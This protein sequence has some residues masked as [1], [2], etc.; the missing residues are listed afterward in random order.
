VS[1]VVSA[2]LRPTYSFVSC[3]QGGAVLRR[4]SD[5]KSCEFTLSL[6]VERTGAMPWPLKLPPDQTVTTVLFHY[7]R[8]G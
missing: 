6:A 1:R 3:Y 2:P 8:G 4:H 7:V 5:R